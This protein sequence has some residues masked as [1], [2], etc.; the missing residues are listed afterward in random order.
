MSPPV[1]RE[2]VATTLRPRNVAYAR[3]VRY[4][5]LGP[6]RVDDAGRTVTIPGGKE[7]ALLG[8][9]IVEA[10]TVVSSDRITYELWGDQ[11]PRDPAAALRTH[12]SRLRKTL[13][14]DHI[15]TRRPGY[16]LTAD[17]AAIDAARFEQ[18]SD[19][20]ARA[21][22]PD[23][24]A[25]LARAALTEWRG[26]ALSDLET[27][28]YA[29][30][31]ARR[32][33]QRR[34]VTLEVA[35]DA[36]LR[37]GRHLD[38]VPEL[39][40]LTAAH[41]F[42]ERF[43]QLLMLA[44]YRSGRAGDALAVYAQAET[45][46]GEALGIGP[47]AA[48]RSLERAIVMQEPELTLA[49]SLPPN[50][51]TS[52]LGEFIGR[53]RELDAL[54]ETLERS[55]LVTLTG[56]GGSGKTRLAL[57]AA[58][59]RMTRH[60][61]G[62]WIVELASVRDPDAVPTAVAAALGEPGSHATD[63]V[64]SLVDYLADRRVLLVLDNCEH[65]VAASRE[66]AT[67]L[68]ARCRHLHLLVT[69]REA[70]Q[71]PGET[72]WLVPPLTLPNPTADP[73]DQEDAEAF[74]L[75]V[76]R[77]TAATP[78]F[79]VTDTNRPSI[80]EL[81]RRLGGLP[82]AIELAAARS[83]AFS[84]GQL[85]ERIAR[86]KDLPGTGSAA[87]VRSGSVRSSLEWSYRLLEEPLATVFR[88]TG[89]FIGTFTVDD[90]AAVVGTGSDVTDAVA[91]LVDKSLVTVAAGHAHRYSLLEPVRA[92]AASLLEDAGDASAA[93]SR[94]A[95]RYL[96]VARAGAARLRGPHQGDAMAALEADHDNL[97][98]RPGVVSGQRTTRP[99]SQARRCLRLVLVHGR[100]LARIGHLADE[101][102]RRRRGRLPRPTGQRRLHRRRPPSHPCQHRRRH[103]RH[104]G[105]RR[106][107]PRRR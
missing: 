28:P 1:Y 93:R 30:A 13:P 55:R 45:H 81:C 6:L 7:R 90:V 88:H 94:H 83:G 89:V 46:L 80:T 57:E 53:D 66:L 84:P 42:H 74:R 51:L 36:E 71:I 49:T 60:P 15:A 43:W 73:P 22:E 14:G 61:D 5:I 98:A 82:L 100:P 20:A 58:A 63:P 62:V 101:G 34:L 31:E 78:S 19:D 50:N 38:A 52:P 4:G 103:R 16:I 25:R 106:H 91:S 70:L 9:L 27:Y 23:R 54:A 44:L 56:V 102:P 40:A 87:A 39:T 99:R 26:P 29:A 86:G 10:G 32:L 104:Q 17:P 96:A 48:L 37:T 107:L 68:A 79:T 92:Y 75:F 64:A 35:L 95:E 69:S 18:S 8:L 41:P 11:P 47:S 105:S 2:G 67:T 85:V 12:V 77:A 59:R 76:T 72:Q 97:R 24:A 33:Q 21:R 65:L 3:P